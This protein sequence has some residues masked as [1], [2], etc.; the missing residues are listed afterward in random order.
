MAAGLC[1]PGKIQNAAGM[2]RGN[3]SKYLEMLLETNIIG[4]E[5]L[6]H[7]KRGGIYYIADNFLEFWWRHVYQ[8]RSDLEMQNVAEVA[9]RIDLDA[10][11][12]IMAERAV[13]EVLRLKGWRTSRFIH[14]GTEIDLLAFDD[15]KKVCMVGEVKWEKRPVGNDM[16]QALEEKSTLVKAPPGYRRKYLLFSKS[17]FRDADTLGE[18]AELWDIKTIDS[19]IS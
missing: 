7:R 3:I 19:M 13:R 10:H 2:D 5:R 11:M 14:K 15:T 6:A 9:A 12:A 17:G 8:H 4:Y 1:T 18:K 16:L